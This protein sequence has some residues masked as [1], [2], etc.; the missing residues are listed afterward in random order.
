M[1]KTISIKQSGASEKTEKVSEKVNRRAVTFPSEGETL[2]GW[3]Y[4]PSNPKPGRKLPAIVTANALSGIKEINLPQ[5][6]ERFAA[7]GFVT[8]IFDYRY[9]GE[10]SG[11][12]RFH[13]APVEFRT[14]ISAALTFLAQQPEVDPNRIGGWG[15]SMGGQHMLYLATWEPRFKA[16]VAT[17]TG[18]SNP[19]QEAPLSPEAAKAKYNQMSEAAKTEREGRAKAGIKTLQAWC[20]RPQE[21]CLLPVEEAYNWYQNAKS[22]F[23]PTWENK[24]TSTSFQNLIADDP[25]FAIHLA[26]APILI[27]HPDRDVVS[28]DNVLFYFKRAPEPKRLVIPGGLHTS[29]YV[30]G[31]NMEMAALEAITWFKQYLSGK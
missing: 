27:V 16:I 26:K 4:F 10:S 1:T 15:I 9:W 13:V 29:T 5:Y 3:L 2:R 30:N 7:A 20:P 24:M 25:V 18:I 31:S 19:T 21:G 23:A 11:E 28:V 12:P 6:A 22:T 8:V 14:D 17:A